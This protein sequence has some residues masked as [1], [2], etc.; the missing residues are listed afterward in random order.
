MFRNIVS[1]KKIIYFPYSYV[2]IGQVTEWL[3][4]LGF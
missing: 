4:D 2:E 1:I 3:R